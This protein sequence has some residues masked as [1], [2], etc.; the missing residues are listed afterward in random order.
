[1]RNIT[2]S[3]NA[4]EET[5]RRLAFIENPTERIRLLFTNN[6]KDDAL[7]ELNAL[8]D[9][10]I[11]FQDPSRA[12]GVQLDG[13]KY[14][15]RNGDEPVVT[16]KDNTVHFTLSGIAKYFGWTKKQL[17]DFTTHLFEVIMEKIDPATGWKEIASWAGSWEI[18][19]TEKAYEKYRPK[20]KKFCTQFERWLL[21]SHFYDGDHFFH[22]LG[23][24]WYQ[25]WIGWTKPSKRH[26]YH[27]DSGAVEEQ[28]DFQTSKLNAL[29]T[30][31][32]VMGMTEQD[33]RIAFI[34]WLE[35]YSESGL[36]FYFHAMVV[37]ANPIYCD[38]NPR[39]LAALSKLTDRSLE[40]FFKG[41]M[42]HYTFASLAKRGMKSDPTFQQKYT[43]RLAHVLGKG[44]IGWAGGVN[45]LVGEMLFG[46]EKKV[47]LVS[48]APLAFDKAVAA[49]KFGIAAALVLH[50]GEEEC[51]DEK[52]LS[53][54]VQGKNN[55]ERKQMLGQLVEERKT[56]IRESFGIAKTAGQPIRLSYHCSFLKPY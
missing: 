6:L 51:F 50:F 47:E 55:R 26:T 7:T 22:Y 32:K 16:S 4:V 44:N 13:V 39:K 49:G 2:I 10:G 18:N 9:K 54:R 36:D 53:A 30:R 45:N 8:V 33:V 5:R 34:R 42:H 23:D 40:Q 20:D 52:I 12:H 1:M 41:T 27:D 38:E 17:S 14:S 31:L 19:A 56:Q 21:L 35:K 24:E 43:E 48:V 15:R 3:G 29:A 46:K 25:K 28:T 11:Y 37:N